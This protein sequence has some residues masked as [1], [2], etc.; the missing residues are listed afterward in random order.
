[1]SR[2]SAFLLLIIQTAHRFSLKIDL[3]GRRGC[4]A[5]RAVTPCTED[6][7]PHCSVPGFDSFAAGHS[8]CLSLPHFLS[9]SSQKLKKDLKTKK[10]LLA[11]T[12]TED[13]CSFFRC[14]AQ[15]YFTHHTCATHTLVC[16]Q[17]SYM[18]DSTCR[19]LPVIFAVFTYKVPA[20][21]KSVGRDNRGKKYRHEG[22]CNLI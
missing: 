9:Y 6:V 14:K 20:T 15:T 11:V 22:E 8:L 7:C 1:M 18:V 4:S 16:M 2:F 21:T 12:V 19:V 10:D 5:G 3:L 13:Q 17:Q